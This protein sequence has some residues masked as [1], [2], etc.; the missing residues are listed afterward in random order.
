MTKSNQGG[1]RSN[2]GRKPWVPAELKK[3]SYA[4]KLEPLT[5]RFLRSLKDD[6]DTS[7]ATLIDRE[8]QRTKE[9][10]EWLEV[11]SKS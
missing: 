7:A 6:P 3:Q 2:A 10:R 9:F 5:I 8:V 11:D 4:T 1:K